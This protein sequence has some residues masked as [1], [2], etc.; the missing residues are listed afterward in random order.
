ME[1][2]QVNSWEVKWQEEP[3]R[4]GAGCSARNKPSA[5]SSLSPHSPRPRH[6]SL[7]TQVTLLNLFYLTGRAIKGENIPSRSGQYKGKGQGRPSPIQP[8]VDKLR[9]ILL[10]QTYPF[11]FHCWRMLCWHNQIPWQPSGTQDK[12]SVWLCAWEI[13][14]VLR[15]AFFML[16]FLHSIIGSKVP[17]LTAFLP[18]LSKVKINKRYVFEIS[19]RKELNLMYGYYIAK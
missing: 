6:R 1:P 19:R 17:P 12:S 15:K 7:C 2:W 4:M 14:P 11:L 8:R 13:N 9:S 16:S 18:R 10:L 3:W 5:F